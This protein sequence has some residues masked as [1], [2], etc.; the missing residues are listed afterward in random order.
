[1]L[2]HLVEIIFL[3]LKSDAKAVRRVEKYKA[4]LSM[5]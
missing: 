1:M 2:N 3:G 4:R 5:A